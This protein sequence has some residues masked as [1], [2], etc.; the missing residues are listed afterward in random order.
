MSENVYCGGIRNDRD[1]L[2]HYHA[3]VVNRYLKY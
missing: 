1:D 3:M 2:C